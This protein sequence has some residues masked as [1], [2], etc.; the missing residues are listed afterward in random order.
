MKRK[1][2]GLV[3]V[4]LAVLL[5]QG[6]SK[7][8]QEEQKQDEAQAALESLRDSEKEQI[9]KAL[10]AAIADLEDKGYSREEIMDRI[11]ELREEGLSDQQIIARLKSE[12]IPEEIVE[13]AVAAVQ[14]KTEAPVKVNDTVKVESETN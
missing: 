7:Q 8:K 1:I 13:Q 10:E 6:C 14:A 9:E 4:L 5:V 12:G 11:E 2:G 3:L